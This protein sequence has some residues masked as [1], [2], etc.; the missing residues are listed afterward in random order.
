M[1][2]LHAFAYIAIILTGIC[3][4]SLGFYL[5]LKN[6]SEEFLTVN[7]Y[8]P[9]KTYNGTTLISFGN[10]P[11]GPRIIEIDMTGEILWE[12]ILPPEL[13]EY[14]NPGFDVEYLPNN[15]VLF[16]CPLKGVFE[17]NRSGVIVWSY[18]DDQISHDADRLPNGNT[19]FVF[20]G[21]DNL[22][23]IQVKEVNR[24]GAVVWSWAAKDYYNFS[25]YNEISCQ[26]WTHTNSIT[27]LPNNNTL[28]SLRN[29]NFLVIVN[30]T[31][32]IIKEIG[33]GMIWYPHD[34]EFLSNG[35]ILV[36]SQRPLINCNGEMMLN[37]SVDYIP[38]AEI[39]VTTS[40][41]VWKYN[42]TDWFDV[43]LTRDCDRL[44]NNNTLITGSSKI[45]EVTPSGEIVWELEK[46]IEAILGVDLATQGFYKAERKF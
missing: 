6:Q 40:T 19:L 41:I 39:N 12:Y 37:Y 18:L 34:P 4:V 7:W 32:D 42:T 21:N 36:A 15:N 11:N 17:V 38:V 24:S 43:Q 9:D 10:H 46:N 13:K 33:E 44:P 35:N 45:I 14:I 28:I 31:G 3:V 20:G 2:K 1:K 25:P 30:K 22:T 5:I 23:D 29:F 8:Y 26:G 27:R 16:V